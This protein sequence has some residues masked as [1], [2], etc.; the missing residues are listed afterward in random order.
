MFS[1][2]SLKDMMRI[3]WKINIK[4]KTPLKRSPAESPYILLIWTGSQ[5]RLLGRPFFSNWPVRVKREAVGQCQNK[6]PLPWESPLWA[7][8]IKARSWT[9]DIGVLI[10]GTK[11]VPGV[12]RHLC[13]RR[14]MLTLAVCVVFSDDVRKLKKKNTKRPQNMSLCSFPLVTFSIW[15]HPTYI[16]TTREQPRSE[17]FPS[18]ANAFYEAQRKALFNNNC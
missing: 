16:S 6:G 7:F 17:H 3:K 1:C 13:S 4:T 11:V 14:E 10:S 18:A 8:T 15:A 5:R 2:S 12:W 9:R